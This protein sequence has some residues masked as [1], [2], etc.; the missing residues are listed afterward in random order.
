MVQTLRV[1]DIEIE[2]DEVI[3]H[4][5]KSGARI[6][7]LCLPEGLKRKA[8]DIASHIEQNTGCTVI[9]SGEPCYGACDIDA[10][11]LDEVDVL[12][13][14]GHS[15]LLP[16]DYRVNSLRSKQHME[17]VL[18]VEA[19]STLD[20]LPAVRKAAALLKGRKVGVITT[21]QHVHTL[22]DV[23][24][25][26]RS[27]GFSP[28]VAGGDD[29]VC[30]EGQ[31]L[32]CNFSAARC[33]CEELLFVGGGEFHPMGAALATGMRVVV[34]DPYLNE[35]RVVDTRAIV[36]QRYAAIWRAMDK[37]RFGVVMCSKM[38]QRRPH[39]ALRA[40]ALLREAGR[41]ATL[42]MMDDITIEK[43]EQLGFE[44][45]VVCACPRVAIDEYATFPMPVLTPPELEMVLGRRRMDDLALDE[46]LEG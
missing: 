19:R 6:V 25:L 21:V 13:H 24:A 42:I 33:D 7:G 30:H 16:V 2:L 36:K 5:R 38:G 22:N 8:G 43:L 37:Q 35:A 11:L 4:I 1:D 28:L 27:L 10:A 44:C 9:V 46:I 31:V 40:V 18:Y 23:C 39:A 32:G 26:L 41:D 20:V 45:Y 29:R 14:V 3:E 17:R 15:R 12:V 34:A